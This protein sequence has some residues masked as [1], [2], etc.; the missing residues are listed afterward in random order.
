MST[1]IVATARHGTG[2]AQVLN[3]GLESWAVAN[4]AVWMWL[5]VVQGNTRAERFWAT[6]ELP[7]IGLFFLR[8]WSSRIQLVTCTARA[9]GG[10]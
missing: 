9:A 1:T 7:A 8:R 3:R 4:G 2:D 10:S 5:G 6:H